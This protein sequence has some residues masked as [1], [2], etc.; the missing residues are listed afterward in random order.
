M[1]YY[2]E[3][4]NKVFDSKEELEKAELGALNKDHALLENKLR[5]SIDNVTRA[6]EEL[7]T[8]KENFKAIKEQFEKEL[9]RLMVEPTNKVR[10]AEKRR[11]EISTVFKKQF[12]EEDYK[13][14]LAKLLS[15]G[16][17]KKADEQ[18]GAN[19]I[20]AISEFIKILYL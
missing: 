13:L 19:L 7:D 5:E 18:G 4:L 11:D 3:K 1:K 20:E 17:D 12:G 10:E 6:S 15:A 14:T 8:I 2:S 9:D 16:L